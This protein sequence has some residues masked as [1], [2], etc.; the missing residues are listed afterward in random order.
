M[1]KLIIKLLL[2]VGIVVLT[3]CGSTEA[4]DEDK[5]EIRIGATAGPYSDQLQEGIVPILEKEGYTVKITEFSDYIQPNKALDEGSIDANLFQNSIYLEQFNIDHGMDLVA[6]Y[7]VP[8][9]PIALYS[10]KHESLTDVEE[11]M[12]I[13]LPNDPTNL[14]RSLHMLESYGWITVD[15][16]VQQT[17]ASEKDI[18]ENTYNLDI[19]PIEAAQ[20][21]RSLGDA[22]FAFVNGNFALASDLKLTEAV[23]VEQTPEEFLIYI[24]LRE[25]E[26]N[27]PYAKALE[28]AYRSTEF[29]DYTNEH[30]QGYVKPAY[31]IEEE[32]D[33]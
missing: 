32:A 28:E 12:K 16:E 7:A 21:A 23:D 4:R 24:T 13:T 18:I 1:R 15:K 25:G 8:T 9:A 19:Q 5:K 30:A 10:E 2:V 20:T 22:D 33:K 27:E 11:G 14:A 31:Q 3:A 29:L 26:E 6:P 17:T